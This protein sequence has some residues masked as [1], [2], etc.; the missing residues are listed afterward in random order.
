MQ[1]LEARP[2]P[3]C[4]TG[5]DDAAVR[6]EQVVLRTAGDIDS[7]LDPEEVY[8]ECADRAR[9]VCGKSAVTRRYRTV[10]YT[11]CLLWCATCAVLVLAYL[12]C[13]IWR[14]G[15]HVAPF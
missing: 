15:R 7:Q 13:A 14:R 12:W 5:K 9:G 2:A 6:H 11:F 4:S 3:K 8:R 1:P 10:A